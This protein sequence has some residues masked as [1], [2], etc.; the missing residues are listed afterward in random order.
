MPFERLF[1]TL[2]APEVL[3]AGE[4]QLLADESL[5]LAAEYERDAV[6]MDTEEGRQIALALSGWRRQRGRLFHELSAQ[7]ESLEA[8]ACLEVTPPSF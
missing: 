1:D 5:K 6:F 2:A 3:A 7:A 4:L 8:A